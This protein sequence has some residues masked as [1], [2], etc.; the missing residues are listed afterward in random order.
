M[1]A[2]LRSGA[3]L[4]FLRVGRAHSDTEYMVR[5]ARRIRRGWHRLATLSYERGEEA[6]PIDLVGT[7]GR[8]HTHQRQN[9]AL[10]V[11]CHSSARPV[12]VR[13]QAS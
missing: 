9:L 7:I 5:T 6:R 8:L 4:E 11:A 13:T 10:L 3:T 1:V 2:V 12:V